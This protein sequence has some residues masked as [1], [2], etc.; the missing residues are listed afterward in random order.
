M[1]VKLRC[2]QCNTTLTAPDDI[3][4]QTVRCE[5]CDGTFTAKTSSRRPQVVDEDDAPRR[6][7]KSNSRRL[8]NDDDD[9]DDDDDEFDRPRKKRKPKKNSTNAAPFIFGGLL[10]GFFAIIVVVLGY[11]FIRSPKA[12][13]P[14]MAINIPAPP[15]MPNNFAPL[16]NNAVAPVQPQAPNAGEKVRISNARWGGGGGFGGGFP[17]QGDFT[18][19]Y[20]FLQGR[21]IGGRYKVYCK[22]NDGSSSEAE[23]HGIID[24]RGTLTIKSFGGGFG[25]PRQQ[26]MEIWI[27][28]GG[29]G[30]PFGGNNGT[31]VSN[32][33]TLN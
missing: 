17:G 1:S 3:L 14:Q 22:H 15:M 28:E 30:G 8:A 25:R 9:D 23:M 18:I 13:Q 16:P 5:E 27:V 21:P 7:S 20:E 2:P 33:L 6:P 4:G 29:F 19:E 12:A 32:T 24:Q 31:K 26:G 10:I 11:Y